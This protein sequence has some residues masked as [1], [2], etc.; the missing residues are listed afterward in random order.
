MGASV[1]S[2]LGVGME[3]GDKHPPHKHRVASRSLYK[4]SLGAYTFPFSSVFFFPTTA[5]PPRRPPPKT[6]NWKSQEAG[7]TKGRGS[8]GGW[9]SP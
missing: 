5:T 9:A 3:G 2:K 1:L 8:R 6:L 4:C 7:L